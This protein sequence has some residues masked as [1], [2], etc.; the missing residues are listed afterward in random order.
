MANVPRR[1]PTYPRRWPIVLDVGH[2]RA[3]RLLEASKSK[4][5]FE[6]G[7]PSKMVAIYGGYVGHL[8]RSRLRQPSDLH[9]DGT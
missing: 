1:W 5:A 9:S 2:L 3:H 4:G 6:D 8:R 7:Q